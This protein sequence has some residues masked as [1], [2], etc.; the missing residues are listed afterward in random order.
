MLKAIEATFAR[1]QTVLPAS[2]EVFTEGFANDTTKQ[3]QWSAFLLRNALTGASI[4]FS[5]V[6]DTLRRFLEPVINSSRRSDR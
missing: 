6:M 5:E 3:T 4:H 2:P 1:R